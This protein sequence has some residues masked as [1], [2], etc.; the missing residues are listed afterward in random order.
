MIVGGFGNIVTKSL[1]GSETTH[2]QGS[3]P[4]LLWCK[5][6]HIGI[7]RCLQLWHWSSPTPVAAEWDMKPVVFASHTLTETEKL[8]AQIEKCLASAWASERFSQYLTGLQNFTLIVD[9]KPLVPLMMTKNLNQVP[10]RCQHLL[11][12]LMC[13]N[14]T[15]K[16]VPGK[17]TA[18]IRCPV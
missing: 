12:S 1:Q 18:D 9:H 11:I 8:Y 16:Q 4:S 10:V 15:V 14:P 7:S 13:F 3:S 2:H 6:A 5:E 17:K